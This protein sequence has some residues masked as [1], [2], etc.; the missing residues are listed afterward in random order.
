MEQ[1]DLLDGVRSIFCAECE[2]GH[3]VDIFPDGRRLHVHGGSANECGVPPGQGPVVGPRL[4]LTGVYKHY[5]GEYCLVL[6]LAA[7]SDS[8]NQLAVVYVSLMGE[9]LPGPRLHYS[10]LESWCEPIWVNG[11]EPSHGTFVE[12]YQYVGTEIPQ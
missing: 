8:P 11:D 10:R 6:G 1:L 12:R 4:L 2:G 3:P 9:N 5:K 7:D